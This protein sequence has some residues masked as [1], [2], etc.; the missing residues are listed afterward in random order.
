MNSV[1]ANRYR[2]G[3][4]AMGWHSDDEPELGARPLIASLSLGATR[5]FLL[6]HRR[7]P[8]RRL[9][10]EA[11]A[12]PHGGLVSQP[13]EHHVGQP[14]ELRL[15]RR[16]DVRMPIAVDHRPPRRHPIDQLAPVLEA[17]P[18]P[19][20]RF[21]REERA[22]DGARVGMPDMAS[23]A[24]DQLAQTISP[25]VRLRDEISAPRL[26]LARSPAGAKG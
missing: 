23:I 17:Q 22:R 26:I 15:D 14:L 5:R 11:L 3:R 4:D 1:L 16:L 6:R 18:D 10:G 13:A 24:C 19:F 21:D 25:S 7:E 12:E 8:A 20:G 9:R 2:D